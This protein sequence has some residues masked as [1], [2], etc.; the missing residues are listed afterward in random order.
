MTK[1]FSTI[2]F[3]I[4]KKGLGLLFDFSRQALRYRVVFAA[5]DTLNSS[6]LDKPE[7]NFEKRLPESLR[8]VITCKMAYYCRLHKLSKANKSARLELP[9]KLQ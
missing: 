8:L 7:N 6:Y 5:T 4:S 2:L 9:I 3:L 1:T